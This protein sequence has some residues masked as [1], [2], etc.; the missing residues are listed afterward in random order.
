MSVDREQ[1]KLYDIFI[2]FLKCQNDT[3]VN[4]GE[5]DVFLLEQKRLLHTDATDSI[6]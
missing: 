1:F 2:L 3:L 4:W 5:K 6:T